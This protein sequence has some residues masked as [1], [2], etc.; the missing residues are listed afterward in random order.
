MEPK[1]RFK[2]FNGNWEESRIGDF[3]KVNQGLQIN[4]NDR[5]LEQREN[6]YF[7]ITNE[8]LKEN[9]KTFY[10]IENP[11]PNVICNENDILMTRTGNTGKVVTNVKGVFHNNFFKIDYDKKIIDKN[12]FVYLLSSNKIQKKILI[13]AGSSTI[14]DLNHKDFYKIKIKLSSLSEQI[15]IADFLSTV[16]KKI[17]NQQDKIT[18]LENI[19]KG[20]MQKIFSQEIRFK[21]D[22]GNEFPEWEEKK[23]G[24]IG[25]FKTSS[26]DKLI[27]KDEKVVKLVNY[28]DV[29]RHKNINIKNIDELMEV[30][31]KEN[32]IKENNLIKGDILFTPSSETPDDIGHSIVIFEDLPNTLYSYH[33]V[34]FRPYK[35][36]LDIL[37]SHYFCNTS[38]VLNQFTK[39]SQGATRYTLSLNSFKKVKVKFPIVK[40]E[41]QKIANFLSSFDEKIDVE[42]DILNH[43][44]EMKKGLL[45]QMFV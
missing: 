30:S 40:E 29:Y 22:N 41:Q 4:I 1:L 23:L 17:Q 19:K 11:P 7:Y 38:I 18:H 44:K 25:E 13:L 24:S 12:F 21:D 14:P 3:S 27:N 32:Q 20:F 39:Y 36:I 43:L 2:E 34:R 15:K 37:F 9:S 33:L 6:R 10:Y 8:F 45:Q 35:N 42:K 26:V 31:A 16:D 28:M 5:F